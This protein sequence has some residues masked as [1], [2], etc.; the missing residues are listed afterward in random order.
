[1]LVVEE[2]VVKVVKDLA[3]QEA[4][5]QEDQVLQDNLHRLILVLVEAQQEIKD[6]LVLVDLV[7]LL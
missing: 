7:W 1:M 2:V 6:N 4:V 5:V 3:L